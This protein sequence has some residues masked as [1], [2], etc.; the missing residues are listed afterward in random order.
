MQ[1]CVS[2]RNMSNSLICWTSHSTAVSVS[3]EMY[4]RERGKARERACYASKGEFLEC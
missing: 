4:T 3:E 1:V 2:K